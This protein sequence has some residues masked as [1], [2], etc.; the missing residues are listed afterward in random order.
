MDS[1]IYDRI[2]EETDIVAL[3]S[4]FTTLT[5]RGKN[6][7]GLCPF[8]SEKT[9]SFSVSPE[10]HLAMCM[11]CGKGGNP[12]TFYSQIKNISYNDAAIELASRLGI[13]MPKTVKGS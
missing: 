10:K 11:G 7:M 1:S 2:I 12:I 9:P 4:E 3:A 8:H 5:K 13:N 6:F